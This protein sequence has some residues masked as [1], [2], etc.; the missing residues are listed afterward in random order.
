MTQ[1]RS[2]LCSLCASIPILAA[3]ACG[4]NLKQAPAAPPP[5][6][7]RAVVVAGDFTMGDPGVLSALDLETG[8][9]QVNVGP[10]MAVGS[11]PILRHVGRELLI[12]N[13]AENNITILD[14]RTLG[15]KTQLGTG[16]DSNPQDVAVVGNK[17]YV[18]TY[19]TSGVTV[20]TR[21]S[22][23]TTQ[24]DLSA[25]D[26]DGKPDCNSVYLV[27]TDLYV[28]CELLAGFPPTVAG[29]VYVVD[30]RSDTVKT[31]LTMTLVHKNPFGLFEQFPTGTPNAGDLVVATVEDFTT[32]GCVERI[33]TGATPSVA[34]CLVQGSDLGGYAS[35]VDF[36]AD[37]DGQIMWTA[38]AIP[39]DYKQASLRAY[40]M[41]LRALW[42]G[43]LNPATQMIGDVAHCPSG[44]VVVVDTT[45]AAGGLR[46]YE[47][48]VEQTTAAMPIG[49]GSSSAHGLACY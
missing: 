42:D 47:G 11:D 16:P 39:P 38:V 23:H 1:L 36:E 41:T 7:A 32:P 21:G 22:N 28:S 24:I 13:R 37:S 6:E 29:K 18:A 14:D 49:L 5:I 3:A 26:P 46:I 30:T 35:R 17:L 12:V 2:Q 44:Q 10:A 40:D 9:M 4:D 33:A 20:L 31:D 34:G 27:G 45:P 15:L 19:G 43:A 25:D 48:A 8:T